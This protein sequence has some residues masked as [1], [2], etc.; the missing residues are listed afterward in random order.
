M[1]PAPST[2]KD[3]IPSNF[4][5]FITETIA[6][7][8]GPMAFSVFVVIHRFRRICPNSIEWHSFTDDCR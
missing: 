7:F 2:K 6:F 5:S 1:K 4:R 8:G 3:R